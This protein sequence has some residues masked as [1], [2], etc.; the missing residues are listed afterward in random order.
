[1]MSIIKVPQRTGLGAAARTAD[2]RLDR[3]AAEEGAD[4]VGETG[5]EGYLVDID[6]RI[7]HTAGHTGIGDI[8][9][10]LQGHQR[11]HA[12][13]DIGRQIE[14]ERNQLLILFGRP[15]PLRHLQP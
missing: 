5:V 9:A 8:A 1:M 11:K 14:F 2:D 13:D 4:R 12:A 6:R 7:G 3:A 10:D 15:S